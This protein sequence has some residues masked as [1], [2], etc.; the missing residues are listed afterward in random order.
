VVQRQL[1]KTHSDVLGL[2]DRT[3][4]SVVREARVY[5]AAYSVNAKCRGH[6][7][8]LRPRIDRLARLREVLGE[9]GDQ[10]PL[11]GVEVALPLTRQPDDRLSR[12][13]A[14]FRVRSNFGRGF[15]V[16]KSRASAS[17]AATELSFP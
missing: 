5:I 13:G 14:M 11:Q 7:N 2:L 4:D 6:G 9:I 10:A 3:I 8:G 15:T 16:Q 17:G 1:G 12:V